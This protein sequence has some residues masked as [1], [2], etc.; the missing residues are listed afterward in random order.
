MNDP[1]VLLDDDDV[2]DNKLTKFLDFMNKLR[3]AGM[4]EKP[5]EGQIII[6]DDQ[7]VNLQTIQLAAL[8]LGF[9]FSNLKMFSNGQEV[10]EYLDTLLNGIDMKSR[11]KGSPPQ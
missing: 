10:I 4:L 9:E 6:A 1:I 8:D 11:D 2:A 5:S 7:F 3:V